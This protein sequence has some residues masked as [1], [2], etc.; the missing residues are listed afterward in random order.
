MM[1]NTCSSEAYP[2][3][4]LKYSLYQKFQIIKHNINFLSFFELLH[5]FIS[6]SLHKVWCILTNTW[7]FMFIL[8]YDAEN[9]IGQKYI[10]STWLNIHYMKSVRSSNT[11]STFFIFYFQWMFNHVIRICFRSIRVL[12]YVLKS[13]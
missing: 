1:Y 8:R 2:N 9:V 7:A 3:H 4:I 6:H 12:H 11:T 13:S 10:R 5:F